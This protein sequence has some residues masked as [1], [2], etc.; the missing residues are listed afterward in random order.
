MQKDKEQQIANAKAQERRQRDEIIK[1]KLKGYFSEKKQRNQISDGKQKQLKYI[2]KA[3]LL[4][5][6]R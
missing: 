5:S 4:P 6:V 1:F 3:F 2:L